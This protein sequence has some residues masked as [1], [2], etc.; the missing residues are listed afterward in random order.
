MKQA[1]KKPAKSLATKLVEIVDGEEIELIKQED[2]V[3]ASMCENC[4]RYS[5]CHTCSFLH[6]QLCQDIGLL[7]DGPAIPAILKGQC[8]PPPGTSTFDALFLE[9][10]KIAEA[11]AAETPTPFTITRD[12][13]QKGWKK[14]KE[15][16]SAEPTGLHFGHFKA[17]CEHPQI[18][19]FDTIVHIY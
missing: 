19:E 18:A 4:H 11:I 13:H 17:S 16:T 3:R 15:H 14:Q 8:T 12:D 1:Q 7:A 2:L 9:S 6:G 5:L 10:C